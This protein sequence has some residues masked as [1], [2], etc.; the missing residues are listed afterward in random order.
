VETAKTAYLDC[1]RMSSVREP[2][3]V[4]FCTML[5]GAGFERRDDPTGPPLQGPRE[6]PAPD[7]A[8]APVPHGSGGRAGGRSAGPPL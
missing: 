6:A 8:R 3:L 4:T 7:S 5:A 2:D 1:A